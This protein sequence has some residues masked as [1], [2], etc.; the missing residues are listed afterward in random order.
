MM[1]IALRT[2]SFSPPQK[3]ETKVI[4]LGMFIAQIYVVL[5]YPHWRT[6][7]YESYS[8]SYMLSFQ[9]DLF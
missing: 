2:L 1:A 3:V 8:M 6:Y 9:K 5:S 7:V 4:C